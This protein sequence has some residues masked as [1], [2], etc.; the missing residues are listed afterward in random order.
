MSGV[1]CDSVALTAILV[2]AVGSV[3]PAARSPGSLLRDPAASSTPGS[4]AVPWPRLAIA[5]E[6]PIQD[7]VHASLANLGAVVRDELIR[8][9]R[10]LEHAGVEYALVG[11]VALGMHGIIRGT[12]DV[13]LLIK[14]SRENVQRIASALRSVYRDD[15]SIEEIQADDLLGD[16]PVVR[17]IPPSEKLCLDLIAGISEKETF[18]SVEAETMEYRG[19]RIRVATPAALHRL[20]KGTP[21]PLDR[22]DAAALRAHFDFEEEE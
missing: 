17:Y 21:R 7:S 6:C 16:Y 18:E 4:L 5:G 8:V 9:F 15:P 10:A 1:I 2:I 14:A 3:A 19:V 13:D 22:Q 12:E 11:S 20:K